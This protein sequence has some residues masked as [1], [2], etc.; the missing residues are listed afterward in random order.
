MPFDRRVCLPH[1]A[2]VLALLRG[3]GEFV[4]LQ[5]CRLRERR[6]GRG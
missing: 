1:P 3:V 6:L 5:A 4:A 2:V